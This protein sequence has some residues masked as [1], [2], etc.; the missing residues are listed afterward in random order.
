MMSLPWDWIILGAGLLILVYMMI[1]IK[2]EKSSY[3]DS[4]ITYALGPI[5][6]P[7]PS[8]WSLTEQ[9]ENL[10]Q[11]ERTDT[12]YDWKAKL[13]WITDQSWDELHLID[14]EEL[15]VSELKK[16]ALEF[17]EINSVVHRPAS[18]EHHPMVVNGHWQVCRIEG[19]ASKAVIERVYYDAYLV[20]DLEL[21]K[22]LYCES[23]SSVLNGL[24]EG[25]Y[26]EEMM[27]NV[28]KVED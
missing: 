16:R 6:F 14:L 19:T 5:K 21:K 12:R 22:H 9:T 8:W 23:Q 7:A 15:M 2:E 10:L 24:V 18:F 17:D 4:F 11:F 1:V 3:K 26:F 25:P 13:F 27:E 20:R 28:Q